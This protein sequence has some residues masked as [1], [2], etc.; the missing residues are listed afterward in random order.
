M[1]K[2][3][4]PT[5][6]N[7]GISAKK[8]W[9]STV[10]NFQLEQHHLVTLEQACRCLDRIEEAKKAIDRD[11]A[12]IVNRSGGLRE[13]PGHKVEQGNRIIFARLIRELQLDVGEVE[14]RP[15]QLY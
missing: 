8:L 1:K 10:T 2:P 9:F 3:R 6:K 14:S 5:P 4:I 7:L 11:G 12:Y 15:P 13:H